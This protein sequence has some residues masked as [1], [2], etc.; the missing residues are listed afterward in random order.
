MKTP[1][2]RHLKSF[3][4]FLFLLTCFTHCSGVSIVEFEQVCR[5]RISPYSVRMREN[6]DQ[7]NSQYGHFSRSGI[8]PQKSLLAQFLL[9][10]C[11]DFLR[12]EFSLF[13]ITL[14]ERDGLSL[15][16][17]CPN[18]EFFSGP[19][20]PVFGLNTGKYGPEKLRFWTLFT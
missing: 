16:E 4:F 5:L 10:D 15:R 3:R 1:R 11:T 2:R 7:N 18:T 20:F 12:F 8:K 19:Y 17:K 13:W 9:N 6:A 14:E